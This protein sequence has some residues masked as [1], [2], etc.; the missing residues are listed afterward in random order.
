[1][2]GIETITP[3]TVAP[4]PV[5]ALRGRLRLN[6]TAEDPDL[7]EFLAAAVE[8]FEDD[9]R[10]PVLATTYRQDLSC[11]P[12]GPI[13]IARGG[14][15]AVNAVGWYDADGE[16]NDLDP[17]E[18]R[19]EVRTP[20]ARVTLAANPAPVVTA[21]GIDVATVGYVT[22]TAGWAT[23]AAVPRRVRTA[24][25]L[26]AGHF[27]EHREAFLE[28]TLSELPSGWAA[29]VSQYKLGLSGDLGQ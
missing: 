28:G 6:G 20:P 22:F 17:A 21:A 4:V 3:P 24:I 14:V 13:V 18:W 25:M 2:Y 7:E 11:W 5:A 16:P 15:T 27:Y 29:V 12:C 8:Q 1:M 26:L 23:P 10:R 19:A 9:A